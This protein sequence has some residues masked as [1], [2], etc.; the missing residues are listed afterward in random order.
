MSR[1]EIVV[2]QPIE[3]M[4][5]VEKWRYRPTWPDATSLMCFWDILRDKAVQRW[6]VGYAIYHSNCHIYHKT[7]K[8]STVSNMTIKEW[9]KYRHTSYKSSTKFQNL[10]RF[11]SRLAVVFAQT[12]EARC[13]VE[14]EDV[15]GAVSTAMLQLHV[16]DQQFHCLLRCVYIRGSTVISGIIGQSRIWFE[17]H[18]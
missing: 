6:Y 17:Y 11:S 15:V 18:Y 13:S 8:I 16:S 1:L 14:N 9:S 3:T 7:W 2:V 4:R 5:S 12:I 10:K